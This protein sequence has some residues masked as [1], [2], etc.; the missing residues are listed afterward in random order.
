MRTSGKKEVSKRLFVV[1]DNF[2][3]RKYCNL[4]ARDGVVHSSNERESHDARNRRTLETINGEGKALRYMYNPTPR[5][6]RI[7]HVYVVACLCTC[8]IQEIRSRFVHFLPFLTFPQVES[9]VKRQPGL[10]SYKTLVDSSNP[11]KYCV[12]T[13]WKSEEH[14]D[15]WLKD[16]WYVETTRQ[17]DE[18]SEQ[19][20]KYRVFK[21][22]H[23]DVFL[24]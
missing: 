23:E 18:V 14:L 9:R 8:H 24:L 2:Y 20:A 4:R 3:R 16:E 13:K 5:I 10:L 6:M 17:L 21:S 15:T 1:V 11:N 12:L 19:P 7:I 22:P